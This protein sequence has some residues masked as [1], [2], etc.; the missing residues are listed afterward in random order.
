MRRAAVD[1]VHG[2]LCIADMAFDI[3]LLYLLKRAGLRVV[4]VPTEWTDK[5]GFQSCVGQNLA[6]HAPI[7]VA[8]ALDL[9]SISRFKKVVSPA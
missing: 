7:G 3:N 5:V 6:H 4:E 8:V 2:D 9:F 1:H